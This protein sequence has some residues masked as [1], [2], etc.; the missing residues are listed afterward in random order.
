MY[1]FI[2]VLQAELERRQDVNS[3][4][5]LRSFAR[6]LEIDASS[7]SAILKSQRAYPRK[8][9]SEVMDKLKLTEEKRFRFISSIDQFKL[10][11]KELSLKKR[12]LSEVS[13]D[14]ESLHKNTFE[15]S[16]NGDLP[17]LIKAKRIIQ[18]FNSKI[19][20]SLEANSPSDQNAKAHQIT[21]KIAPL[22]EK[23]E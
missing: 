23:S 14:L 2:E 13:N 21:I 1:Y 19:R 6:F 17:N 9:L 7:L 20:S 10:D 4:Y 18:K 12:I 22:E 15:Y 3:K 5:S 16:F 8:K 11:R